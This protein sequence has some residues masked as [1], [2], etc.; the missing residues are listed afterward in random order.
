M[1]D[2]IMLNR[3]PD[4]R[5]VIHLGFGM[6]GDFLNYTGARTAK[7]IKSYMTKERGGGGWVNCYMYSHESDFGSVY[8]GLDSYDQ[9]IIKDEYIEGVE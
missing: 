5:I 9:R 4:N 6:E 1:F 2:D 7:A 8:V 3:Y